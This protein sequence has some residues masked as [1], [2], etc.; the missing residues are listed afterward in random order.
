MGNE[1]SR[2]QHLPPGSPGVGAQPNGAGQGAGPNTPA[3]KVPLPPQYNMRVIIRGARKTGKSSLMARLNGKPLAQEY[4]PTP[5][6]V[7]SSFMWNYKN[8]EDRIRIEVLDVVD[9]I[10]DDDKLL[11]AALDDDMP[12]GA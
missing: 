1:S 8:T 7:A 10:W 2:P 3:Q 5:E 12:A 4:T 6:I 9:R 11:G